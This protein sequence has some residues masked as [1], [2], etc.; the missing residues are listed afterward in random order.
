MLCRLRPYYSRERE[1]ETE[2]E[3]EDRQTDRHKERQRQQKTDL[4]KYWNRTFI[5]MPCYMA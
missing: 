5:Y 3:T 1:R 2:T 4:S